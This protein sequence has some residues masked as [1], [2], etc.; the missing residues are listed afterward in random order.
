MSAQQTFK[1]ER[2]E[3]LK[4]TAERIRESAPP[5]NKRV[6]KPSNRERAINVVD[7]PTSTRNGL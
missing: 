1:S 7:S 4:D 2:A 5:K 3:N 6:L